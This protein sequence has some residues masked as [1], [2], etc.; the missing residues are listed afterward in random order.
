MLKSNQVDGIIMG[1]HTVGVEEYMNL[2]YP[3]VTFD[4]Y[5]GK[6]FLMFRPIIITEVNWRP[7]Y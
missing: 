7:D 6:R 3:I 1:S 4:R 2:P 5:I